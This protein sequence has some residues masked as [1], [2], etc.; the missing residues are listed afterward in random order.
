M[1]IACKF[2]QI[3]RHRIF[4]NFLYLNFTQVLNYIF[5]LLTFPYMVRVFNI[6]N[7]G[8]YV[9]IITLSSYLGIFIDFG[10]GLSATRDIAQVSSKE[11]INKIFNQVITAKFYLFILGFFI[12][13][14][15]CIFEKKY[16]VHLDL[17]VLSLI[18]GIG[19]V[20]F[21]TWLFQA[22]NRADKLAKLNIFSRGLGLI[23]LFVL[24]HNNDD[25][26]KLIIIN[27][28]ISIIIGCLAFFMAINNFSLKFRFETSIKQVI[29]VLK[30]GT[31]AFL[32]IA[33]ISLYTAFNVLFLSLLD[34]NAS[35]AI[36]SVAD[37]ILGMVLSVQGVFIQAIYPTVTASANKEALNTKLKKMFK[38]NLLLGVGGSVFLLFFAK[39]VIIIFASHKY[40]KSIG[41]LQILSLV[42]I[43]MTFASTFSTKLF[44]M[45]A[46]KY[47]NIALVFGVSYCFIANILMIKHY[48]YY[49]VGFNYLICEI[50]QITIMYFFIKKMQY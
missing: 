3:I 20:L 46:E 13:C 11:H 6:E 18:G 42:P 19:S 33:L 8:L 45:R 43:L 12:I 5:P 22:M 48:S 30:N 29:N 23:M 47:Q 28:C 2:K 35:V 10:F 32:V 14:V 15:F 49:A 40:E 27:S 36:Y 26:L 1:A 50:I 34:G 7:Y 25:M 4:K 17:I 44:A 39:Y 24:I 21:P 41:V 38:Y 31:S 16:I 37:K 9:T